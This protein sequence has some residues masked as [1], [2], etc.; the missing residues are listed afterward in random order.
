M[1]TT[2]LSTVIG[3]PV[4]NAVVEFCRRKGLKLRHFIEEALLERLEDELD[5]ET[6]RTRKNEDTV[7]F[8]EILRNRKK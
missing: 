2:S 4:K 7:P 3:A 6:Y 8:E 5:L 1:K